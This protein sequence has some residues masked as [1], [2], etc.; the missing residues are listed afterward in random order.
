M[1]LEKHKDGWWNT[2]RYNYKGRLIMI[3]SAA[4][5]GMKA[6]AFLTDSEK[7]DFTLRYYNILPAVLLDKIKAKIDKN[8]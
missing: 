6:H 8:G 2:T 3:K 4:S 7:V 5:K 1:K